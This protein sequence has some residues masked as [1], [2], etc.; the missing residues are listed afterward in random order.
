MMNDYKIN[1]DVENTWRDT[2]DNYVI[3][4]NPTED[5]GTEMHELTVTITLREY[6]ELI[7]NN[8]QSE[9]K[10]EKADKRRREA[11]EKARAVE[12]ELE[13]LRRYLKNATE[14]EEE[15]NETV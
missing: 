9:D 12:Q 3:R 13:T 1:K 6:R 15:E 4:H 8:A 14:E 11:E 5:D 10:I 2:I 7:K